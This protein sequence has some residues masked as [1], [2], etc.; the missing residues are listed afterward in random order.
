MTLAP[1]KLN[2]AHGSLRGRSRDTADDL[3]KSRQF[4]ESVPLGDPFRAVGDVDLQPT[5]QCST[6]EAIC[7]AWENRASQDEELPVP[8]LIQD[9]VD[10][11]IE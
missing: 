1:S 9:P 6:I 8:H 7:D 3:G 2:S 5:L 11:A 4:F 10:R